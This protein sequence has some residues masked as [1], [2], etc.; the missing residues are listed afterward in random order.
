MNTLLA[1][2]HFAIGDFFCRLLSLND[3]NEKWVN[4]F[5]GLYQY[6]MSRSVEIQDQFGLAGPWDPK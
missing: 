5:F 3:D 6:H 4:M 2:S 1:W